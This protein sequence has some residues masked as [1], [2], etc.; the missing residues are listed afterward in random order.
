MLTGLYHAVSFIV[1]GFRIE[2]ESFAPEFPTVGNLELV[3]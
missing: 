3:R 2:N 1:N